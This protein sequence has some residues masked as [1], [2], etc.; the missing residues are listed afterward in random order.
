MQ[1]DHSGKLLSALR[2]RSEELEGRLQDA[3]TR[4][5]LARSRNLCARKELEQLKKHFVPRGSTRC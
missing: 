2:K 3:R 4:L 1:C 5:E